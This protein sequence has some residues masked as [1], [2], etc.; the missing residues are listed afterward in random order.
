MSKN[1]DVFLK[2]LSDDPKLYEILNSNSHLKVMEILN[3]QNQ[4]F[5]V[6]KNSLGKD[7]YI[8]K[9]IIIYNILD[10]LINRNLAKK[11]KINEKDFYFLT[12]KGISFYKIYLETKKEFNII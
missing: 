3:E 11:V 9:D 12:E 5:Q 4:D 8:D 1:K 7:I 2:M 10:S 6:I